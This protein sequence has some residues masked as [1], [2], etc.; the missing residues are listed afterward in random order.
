MKTIYESNDG[1]QFSTQ[2]ECES[3]DK[4]AELQLHITKFIASTYNEDYDADEINEQNVED[5]IRDNIDEII[6]MVKSTTSKPLTL[7]FKQATEI[8]AMFG[9]EPGEVT[10]IN[11]DDIAAHAGSGL[12]AYYTDLCEEGSGYLGIS[13]DEATPDV[14]EQPRKDWVVLTDKEIDAFDELDL[15]YAERL[16]RVNR[17]LNAKNA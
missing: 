11:T 1:V 13:D 14:K 16:Y 6:R 4:Q 8:L 7:D 15:S 3:H 17:M 12:Y 10:L 9:G 2:A 5:Y